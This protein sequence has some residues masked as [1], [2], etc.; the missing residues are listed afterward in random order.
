MAV[1]EANFGWISQHEITF[2][3]PLEWQRQRAGCWELVDQVYV[4]PFIFV[5]S[6]LSLT[7]GREVYGWSKILTELSPGIHS[8]LSDPR[9][10]QRLMSLR[11][12]GLAG[13]P[14]PKGVLLAEV[15]SEPP[16][17]PSLVPP[18]L[19]NAWNPL[20]CIPRALLGSWSL[21][22]DFCDLSAALPIR[23]YGPSPL[24]FFERLLRSGRR[25]SPSQSESA[26]GIVT[27]K[28]F[29]DAEHP[30]CACY[31]ALIHSE[32]TTR[33]FNRGGLLG[34]LDLLR[35]DTT[36]G[37]RIR[38]H[39]LEALPIL[40]SLGLE[41]AREVG[42]ESSYVATLRPVF[43]FWL[44]LDLEYGTGQAVCWRTRESDW[45]VAGKPA[46][47]GSGSQA[48]A[49]PRGN[50]YN[51]VQ[52]SAVLPGPFS[53][54]QTTLHG[55]ALAADPGRLKKF[56]DGY[57]NLDGLEAEAGLRFEPWG[58]LVLLV[59]VHGEIRSQA[60]ALGSLP[61]REAGF[62]VPV[63]VFEKR[64]VPGRGAAEEGPYSVALVTPFLFTDNSLLAIAHREMAGHAITEATLEGPDDPRLP[65][66]EVSRSLL[67]VVKDV[68]PGLGL[69]LG[70]EKRVLVE[71]VQ[72]PGP[73]DWQLAGGGGDEGRVLS[74]VLSLARNIITLKQFRDAQ[75]PS[76]AC[77]QSFVSIKRITGA[78]VQPTKITENI[79]VKIHRYPSHPVAEMLGLA[80]DDSG[81][82]VET[83]QPLLAVWAQV[84]LRTA[85]LREICWRAGSKWQRR[86]EELRSL[87]LRGETKK[88]VGKIETILNNVLDGWNT[89]L[90]NVPAS[91][92]A[93]APLRA[94]R[95]TAQAQADYVEFT[96][97]QQ[98]PAPYTFKDVRLRGFTLAASYD[99]L[100]ELCDRFL[101]FK[102]FHYEPF[103]TLIPGQSV[104]YL[105]ALTYGSIRS[106]VPAYG[107]AGY[108]QQD[109][110]YFAVPVIDPQTGDFGLFTPV[111]FVSNPWSLTAGREV[112]GFPK[113][114]GQFELP[115]DME[116]PYPI[117]VETMAFNEFQ[118]ESRLSWGPLL[119][120]I[121]RPGPVAA[122]EEFDPRGFWPFGD[123]RKLHGDRGP[124]PLKKDYFDRLEEIAKEMSYSSIQLKQIRGLLAA[125]AAYQEVVR[126]TVKLTSLDNGGFLPPAGIRLFTTETLPTADVLGL[127]VQNGVVEPYLPFWLD[128]GFDFLDPVVV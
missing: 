68:F 10:P 99:K 113:G 61:A 120:I 51:T 112:L 39:H 54:P 8:W 70:A 74:D 78:M 62:F 88:E 81:A 93:P 71:L 1:E 32:M 21:L 37:Y 67:R 28:Q 64:T 16:P 48:P 3:I 57:L 65:G 97:G 20:V 5:D 108:S 85:R 17:N 29:R 60:T 18:D 12:K 79:Q 100:A 4:N 26:S 13:M 47:K 106:L 14:A 77:Y 101:N 128:C 69:G 35:G 15:V 55:F 40:E 87:S 33:R 114:L 42:F 63:K 118:P 127:D 45:V 19:N 58:N 53:Y 89:R 24:S 31:Q 73:A 49:A 110:V 11:V 104:V 84:H 116:N 98:L 83:F 25:N 122:A 2:S 86:H 22:Q 66:P 27:L 109:E 72:Q 43:P 7:T 9:G 119:E 111:I 117:R 38:L 103:P 94:A 123:L 41:A 82:A 56:V 102:G 121:D 34:D 80:G 105:Q 23:G 107:N 95:S 91:A 6:P 96:W 125:K 76:R 46:I 115:M 44:D 52:G 75:D 92:A 90:G 30:D 124:L 126:S 36:G 50:R 59:V